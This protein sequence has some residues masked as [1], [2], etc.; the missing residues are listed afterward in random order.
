M[1]N[2]EIIAEIGCNHRGSLDTALQM[3]DVIAEIGGVGT[4]KFQKRHPKSLLD[5]NEYNSP[6][7]VPT[8]SYGKTYGEHREHLELSMDDH[9]Q[10]ASYCTSVGLRYSTSVW[11]L[12]SLKNILELQPELIKI[13]S[14]L[15]TNTELLSTL[16]RDFS[17]E[18]HVSLGMTT[19][20]EEQ[21]LFDLIDSFDRLGDLVVYACT[22]GYPVPASEAFILEVKRLKRDVGGTVKAIGYSGHH[23]GTNIDLMAFA[24]GAT[25][26]ERHFTLDKGWKG[27][28]HQ[29][30]LNPSELRDLRIK[31]DEA[32]EAFQP[33]PTE[34][35]RVEVETRRKLKWNGYKIKGV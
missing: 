11:D 1:S 5:E 10:I 34:M 25:Q 13:P 35:S 9:R 8:N 18:I 14:A 27:T 4:V 7:P 32:V 19:P 15:N 30:S 23:L 24:L 16:C 28:D 2:Y 6:H 3:V 21:A 26:F 12:I 22:S 33:K 31:L 29:A 20:Q 17:G